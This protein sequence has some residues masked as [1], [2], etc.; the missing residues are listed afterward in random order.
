MFHERV[1][2]LLLKTSWVSGIPSF[3][4]TAMKKQWGAVPIKI[5]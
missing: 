2:E 1:A 3:R 5:T 4:V